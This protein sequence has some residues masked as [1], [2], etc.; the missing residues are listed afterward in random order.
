[1]SSLTDGECCRVLHHPALVAW[2]EFEVGDDGV[3][4]ELGVDL[5]IGVAR[6]LFVSVRSERLGVFNDEPR[7]LSLPGSGRQGSPRLRAWPSSV[8][9]AFLTPLV[10]P[11]RGTDSAGSIDLAAYAVKLAKAVASSSKASNTVSSFV[12]TSRSRSRLVTFSSLSVPPRFLL[13]A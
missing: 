4:R 9:P 6:E 3:Q 5:S 8:E 13:V 7:D 1:M 11:G 2:R 10:F 12:T